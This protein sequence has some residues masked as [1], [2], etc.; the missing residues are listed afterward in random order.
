LTLADP[1]AN[2]PGLDPQGV[3]VS[4]AYQQQDPRA[5]LYRFVA[6]REANLRFLAAL[7]AP[8]WSAAH[9]HPRPGSIRAGDLLASWV[10]Q[11]ALV[12]QSA[13]ERHGRTSG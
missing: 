2:W 6:A 13:G 8:D 3:A 1:R 4:R 12:E 7:D 9:L 5:A 11:V 10:G